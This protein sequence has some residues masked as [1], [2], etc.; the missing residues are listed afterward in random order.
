MGTATGTSDQVNGQINLSGPAAALRRQTEL[1]T[2]A[3]RPVSNAP[4]QQQ[5][6]HQQL[7][8]SA[9][10]KGVN[11]GGTTGHALVRQRL[12]PHLSAQPAHTRTPTRPAGGTLAR[13]RP[14]SRPKHRWEGSQAP[15]KS[16]WQQPPQL[17]K[18]RTLDPAGQ[19]LGLH[20]R[21]KA[22]G[23]RAVCKELETKA[24][25]KL[26]NIPLSARYTV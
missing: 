16:C 1:D 11:R 19:G 17:H 24:P 9:W 22:Q 14:A 5:R 6:S 26:W 15:G 3:S 7:T 25:R 20:P 21:G 8:A 18:P 4:E 23:C 2:T 12:R 10:P 13:Q